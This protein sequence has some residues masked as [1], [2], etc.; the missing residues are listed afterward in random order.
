MVLLFKTTLQVVMEQGFPSKTSAL[1]EAMFCSTWTWGTSFLCCDSALGQIAQRGYGISLTEVFQNHLDASLCQVLWG[2]PAGVGRWDQMTHCGGFQ[3]YPLSDFVL[4]TFPNLKADENVWIVVT[5]STLV[6]ENVD[7]V[8][9]LLSELFITH[10]VSAH[11]GE[12]VTWVSN[13]GIGYP[14][15]CNRQTDHLAWIL[16][17]VI[18]NTLH[19]TVGIFS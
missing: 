17:S 8:L 10:C 18:R 7:S 11:L 2:D 9:W 12:M 14:K 15:Y 1:V 6:L 13:T 5:F 19:L 16:N 3:L 4:E